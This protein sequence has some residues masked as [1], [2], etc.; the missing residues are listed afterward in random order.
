[1]IL[2][3]RG[4]NIPPQI[5][6]RCNIAVKKWGKSMGEWKVFYDM[7]HFGCAVEGDPACETEPTE[8]LLP[9]V[10]HSVDQTVLWYGETWKILSLYTC[11][12]GF[13][14]DYCKQIGAEELD[15]FVNKFREAGLEEHFD[16][17]MFQKLQLENPTIPNAELCV[18]RGD[19]K[20]MS[21]GST[22]LHYRPAA[23]D[24]DPDALSY[25]EH[26]CLDQ[27][28]SYSISRACY[29]WDEGHEE[30]LSGL[31][32]TFCERD[33]NIPG[34]SFTLSGEKQDIHL[35]HP[36]TKERYIMHVDHI[37]KNELSKEHLEQLDQM[38][39]GQMLYPSHYETVYYTIE[40]E[41]DTGSYCLTACVEGHSP[42]A[43][44]C[45]EK[46][47]SSISVIGSVCGPTS[48]FI[49]GKVKSGYNLKCACS[50]LFFEPTPVR[51]WYINFC[52][53][54][55]EELHVAMIC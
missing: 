49:A 38:N 36:V 55:R 44:S 51:E 11:E 4:A 7:H 14:V 29:M 30:D 9:T 42:V 41:L 20:L 3:V 1:M 19:V 43:K 33:V 31:T 25:V 6:S 26:Y 17:K 53:R 2:F 21:R 18:S 47:A 23:I 12:K 8:H 37:E 22:C 27:S 5:L 46:A 50:P 52:V 13:L 34:E 39:G 35:V 16:E 40:P 28:F 54:R 24:D 45:S 15:A 10:E 32:A 48:I